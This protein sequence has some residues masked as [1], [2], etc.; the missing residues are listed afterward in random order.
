MKSTTFVFKAKT[1]LVKSKVVIGAVV[2]G[3]AV[4][5]EVATLSSPAQALKLYSTQNG[6]IPCSSCHSRKGMTNG[7]MYPLT[8]TGTYFKANNQLPPTRTPPPVTPPPYTP[9]GG[10]YTP[11]PPYTPPGGGYNPPP[12]YTPPGG[13]YNPPP[14]RPPV[15]PHVAWCKRKYRSYKERTDQYRGYDGFDHTCISPYGGGGTGGGYTPPPRPP[16]Y[17]PPP[18]PPRYTPPPRPPRYT[19][20]PRPRGGYNPPPRP[21]YLSCREVK[22]ILRGQGYR[23]IRAQKCTGGRYTFHANKGGNRWRLRIK[24]RTGRIYKRTLDN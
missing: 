13:G 14:R 4:S 9:P 16:R 2:L 5:F 1:A 18:R 23:R 22:R 20:P 15:S 11:P 10:G 7:T 17:T 19:P 12:P 3:L 21:G 24:G 6:G 8:S